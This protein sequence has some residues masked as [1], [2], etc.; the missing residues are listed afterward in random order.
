MR[1][2]FTLIELLVVI[3]IIAI[4]AAMLLPALNSAREKARTI[5][6]TGNFGQLS[7][8]FALYSDD[9]QEFA[10]PYRNGIQHSQSNKD[11][12]SVDSR[13]AIWPYLGYVPLASGTTTDT[14]YIGAYRR[15]YSGI[16]STNP[17]TCPSRKFSSLGLTTTVYSLGL[18][19]VL[20]YNNV[21]K[22]GT[23]ARP[24]RSSYLL[25]STYQ[26]PYSSWEDIST[27]T[28]SVAFPHSNPGFREQDSLPTGTL[29]NRPG[30]CNAFF[31]DFH[32]EAVDRP[33][34]PNNLKPGSDA[35]YSSFWRP[36]KHDSDPDTAAKWND[37]W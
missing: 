6:C 35:K 11:W 27:T 8:A 15:T 25:E 12:Y 20:W 22:L 18:N 23:V 28:N 30:K 9:N 21:Y 26:V 2:H 37:N 34:I 33:K 32:V 13:A 1:K 3:A 17:L 31:F 29:V 19:Q 36:W 7:K 16:V 4:L 5:K 10:V 14:Y 24:S